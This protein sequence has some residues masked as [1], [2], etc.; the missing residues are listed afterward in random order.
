[1]LSGEWPAGDQGVAVRNRL[2]YAL[3]DDRRRRVVLLGQQVVG[4]GPVTTLRSATSTGV[5]LVRRWRQLRASGRPGQQLGQA[6][7][8]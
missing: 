4:G 8:P 3:V 7:E 5:R 2:R 1:M 6:V